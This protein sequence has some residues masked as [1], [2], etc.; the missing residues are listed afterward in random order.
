MKAALGEHLEFRCEQIRPIEAPEHDEYGAGETLQ[1]AGEQARAAV[2]TEIPVQTS[3]GFGDVMEGFRR[4]ADQC[5]II[6]GNAKERGHL[7][8]GGP[9]AV[10][11]MAVGNEGRIRCELEFAGATRA[12]AG[13]IFRHIILALSRQVVNP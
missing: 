6:R 2:G 5:K 9:F 12:L 8:T 3:A 11:A 10:V 1:V 13:V 7:A 4:A